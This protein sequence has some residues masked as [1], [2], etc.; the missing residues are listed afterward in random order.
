LTRARSSVVS[1]GRWPA[2]RSACRTQHPERF[3]PKPAS[4]AT[5]RRWR[6][7][8]LAGCARSSPTANL[9]LGKLYRRTGKRQEASE[10]LTI[11]TTMYREMDMR[12][13]LEQADAELR[14]LG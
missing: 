8:N 7:P 5:A 1:P 9:G 3:D 4:A 2:S 6:S 11:A 12:F 14:E 13:W 10:H